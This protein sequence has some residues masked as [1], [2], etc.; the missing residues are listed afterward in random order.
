MLKIVGFGLLALLILSYAIEPLPASFERP[1]DSEYRWPQNASVVDYSYSPPLAPAWN[2]RVL[3]N[4]LSSL[5]LSSIEYPYSKSIEIRAAEANY[6]IAENADARIE[7]FARMGILPYFMDVN[8][9]CGEYGVL[10]C[11]CV[12]VGAMVTCDIPGAEAVRYA[13]ALRLFSSDYSAGWKG[14]MDSALDALEAGASEMNGALYDLEQEYREADYAG[15]CE[16]DVSGHGACENASLFLSAIA[17]NST[18]PQYVE[19]TSIKKALAQ[20]AE[21]VHADVP[22]LETG[23]IVNALGDG[24][25]GEIGRVAGLSRSVAA[26]LSEKLDDYAV[27][28]RETDAAL[29]E[30]KSA[31][32]SAAYHELWR[33]RAGPSF[34]GIVGDEYLAVS[35]KM[36]RGRE[37]LA[38]GANNRS[39]SG[40]AYAYQ[41][42]G[43]L[44]DA[45]ED[46]ANA[47]ALAAA[48]KADFES[49]QADASS[50]VED[51]EAR[52]QD[53]LDSVAGKF[54]NG[55]WPARAKVL[56]A[57]AAADFEA[58]RREKRLGYKFEHYVSAIREA[59]DAL[60]VSLEGETDTNW[61]SIYTCGMAE[62]LIDAAKK[63]G[64]DTSAEEAMY[65]V[66]SRSQNASERIE[67]CNR[68][69]E[70]VIWSAKAKYAGLEAKRA[71]ALHMLELCGT[72]CN[73]L[74]VMMEEA[75]QGLV[76]G[77]N[78][79]Y[80]EAIGSLKTLSEK[81]A[82]IR[83]KYLES[84]RL[85]VGEHLIV[86]RYFFAED[87]VLDEQAE[88]RLQ[89]EVINEI[90]YPGEDI[91]IEV[92]SPVEFS[93]E[94]A[95]QGADALRGVAYVNGRLKLYIGEIPA[96]GRLTF[97]FEKRRVLLKTQSMEAHA[98]G[99]VDGSALVEETRTVISE[100]DLDGFYVPT[101][102]KALVVDGVPASMDNGFVRK[103][104][105]AG[106]HTFRASYEAQD[107]YTAIVCG[108]SSTLVGQRTYQKY[109][110]CVAPGISMDYAML[111]VVVPDA[112]SVKE[113]RAIAL[114]G[115]KIDSTAIPAGLLLK[116]YNLKAA[117]EARFEVSYYADNSS[118]YVESQIEQLESQNL[119]N[120]TSVLVDAAALALAQNDTARAVWLINLAYAQIAKEEKESA[121]LRREIDAYYS[122]VIAELERISNVLGNGTETN[123]L[124]GALSARRE[125][126]Q[127]LLQGVEGKGLSDQANELEKYDKGWLPNLLRDFKKNASQEL[128]TEYAAYL[129][130]KIENLTIATEFGEAR[131]MYDRFDA[132]G[133]LEDAYALASEIKMLREAT[134]AIYEK[135]TAENAIALARC[136]SWIDAINDLMKKYGNEYG[137]AKGSRFESMFAL[138]P[139]EVKTA[140]KQAESNLKAQQRSAPA[141]LSGTECNLTYVFETMNQTIGEL[142]GSAM[143]NSENARR[144]LNLAS[145]LPEKDLKEARGLESELASAITNENWV[146][147]LKAGDEIL[148]IA[149]SAGSGMNYDA[150]VWLSAIF[151]AAAIA[152]YYFKQR[153]GG[154]EKKV[155][156]KLEKFA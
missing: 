59:N 148:K 94:D 17:A 96:D 47:K 110:M 11:S 73:D 101:G 58:G 21:G 117:K 57:S 107:A 112:P 50:L 130:S 38:A 16:Q 1:W 68:V 60:A 19:F 85:Q 34:G 29:D 2:V 132:S 142:R 121:K 61:T 37:R 54:G 3:R 41:K 63:D 4:S 93:E 153:K 123:A 83:Q 36:A 149:A 111:E 115:E 53:A 108:N 39:A 106:T 129:D 152:V 26:Q 14:T 156:R 72:D 40:Y 147:A 120:E 71:E 64:I 155:W 124:T 137:E 139:D 74:Q 48:A 78:V 138:T 133:A 80:P 43:Y 9:A 52:A 12:I 109:Q 125:F 114:T 15:V 45:I 103:E 77:G 32:A 98:H 22:L 79:L 118:E 27:L 145:G 135:I 151:V 122:D 13:I 76:S 119:S 46:A 56:Y 69:M 75:E 136:R 44:H 113:K 67:M 5:D 154:G 23:W 42:R 141:A 128:N 81:Y 105:D 8:S 65:S 30:A 10:N 126:L 134:D 49:A 89:V 18:A 90:Q 87:P 127:G 31:N 24:N 97:V 95:V 33:I 55:V 88:A 140:V 104:L 51:Y 20:D 70:S 92:E 66:L 86:R 102:W 131:Q 150:I 62:S 146:K 100:T 116:I 84:I 25:T 7:E 28:L 143:R 144:A 82:Y 35:E 91:R 99:S 6:T